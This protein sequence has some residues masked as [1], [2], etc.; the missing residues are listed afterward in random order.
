MARGE[1]GCGSLLA[2]VSAFPTWLQIVI[3]GLI[4][5]IIVGAATGDTSDKNG[6]SG[7]KTEQAATPPAP[8]PTPAPT[9]KHNTPTTPPPPPSVREQIQGIVDDVDPG[10]RVRKLRVS[11]TGKQ[12]EVAIDFDASENLTKG[13]TKDGFKLDIQDLY[14]EI[15][16]SDVAHRI[17]I[18]D[19]TV[20]YTLVDKYGNE[21]KDPVYETVMTGRTARKI[22]WDNVDAVDFD[23][24]WTL[25]FIHPAFK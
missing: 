4:I 18:V 23:H 13:L 16:T 22:N 21:S 19:I 20:Y 2:L 1:V 12:Y 9:E 5:L 6:D 24:L 8:K 14:T 15:Y 25:V 7:T 3:P 10:D 17:S 11:R